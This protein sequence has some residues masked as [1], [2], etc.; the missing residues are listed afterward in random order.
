MV[1]ASSTDSD[2]QQLAELT[3][4]WM[5]PLPTPQSP[6]LQILRIQAVSDLKKLLEDLSGSQHGSRSARKPDSASQPQTN[7][8]WYH[9]RF[10]DVAKKCKAPCSKAGNFKVGH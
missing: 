3:G 4:S 10:G 6:Q 9:S 5:H 8:Y 1:V 2:V 7:L